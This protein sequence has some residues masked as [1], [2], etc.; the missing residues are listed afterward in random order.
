MDLTLVRENTTRM[1]STPTE[2]M[3]PTPN[4]IST[5]SVKAQP[6]NILV[7]N[8]FQSNAIELK[9]PTMQIDECKRGGGSEAILQK[10]LPIIAQEDP[11]MIQLFGQQNYIKIVKTT[12]IRWVEGMIVLVS[13]VSS[14]RTI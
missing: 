5:N 9:C 1:S 8:L 2:Q 4:A 7:K 6:S 11:Y 14:K 3:S 10:M 13:L 12:T